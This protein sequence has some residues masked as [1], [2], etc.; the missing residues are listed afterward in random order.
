V[1]FHA[2]SVCNRDKKVLY[3]WILTAWFAGIMALKYH[4]LKEWYYSSEGMI[5]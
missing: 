4:D 1:I 2:K 3:I 5:N